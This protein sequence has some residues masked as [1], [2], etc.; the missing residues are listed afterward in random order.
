MD[1]DIFK[2]S[3]IHSNTYIVKI[4]KESYYQSLIVLLCKADSDGNTPLAMSIS[5]EIRDNS[6]NVYFDKNL[7]SDYINLLATQ[8]NIKIKCS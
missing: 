6:L 4:G 7:T 1:D 3:D 5:K 2:Y 8:Q